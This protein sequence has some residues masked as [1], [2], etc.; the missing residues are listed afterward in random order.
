MITVKTVGDEPQELRCSSSGAENCGLEL[1]QNLE[2]IERQCEG[3][4]RDGVASGF[5]K[6]GTHGGYWRGRNGRV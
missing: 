2:M 6:S 5:G 1:I 4:V 3:S